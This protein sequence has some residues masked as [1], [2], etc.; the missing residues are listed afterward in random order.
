MKHVLEVRQNK[1]LMAGM[2]VSFDTE[3]GRVLTEIFQDPAKQFSPKEL[4][5]LG[6]W[7]IENGSDLGTK[8]TNTD[9]RS[10][11]S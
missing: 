2:V 3:Q 6:S 8:Y 7:L 4:R 9:F 5:L 10:F 11:A 1:K